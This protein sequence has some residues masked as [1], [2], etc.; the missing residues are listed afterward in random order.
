MTPEVWKLIPGYPCYEVS[1]LGNIRRIEFTHKNP[2]GFVPKQTIGSDGRLRVTLYENGR[3]DKY[4]VHQLVM[5]AFKGPTPKGLEIRH[6]DGDH[7]HN[8]VT[9]LEF[10]THKQNG[11]DMIA[12]GSHYKVCS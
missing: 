6:L 4:C 7:R 10:G 11:Q 1:D 2:A 3:Q 8:A 5:L 12:H 9:N